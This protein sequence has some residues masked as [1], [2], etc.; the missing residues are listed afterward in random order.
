MAGQLNLLEF[1]LFLSCIE[2]GV[3]GFDSLV[4]TV[5]SISYVP[6]MQTCSTYVGA[7]LRWI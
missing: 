7:L 4:G 1:D 6:S 2:I 5:Y 3:P